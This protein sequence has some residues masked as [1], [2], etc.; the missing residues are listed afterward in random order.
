MSE[1]VR[2]LDYS[3]GRPSAAAVINNGYQFVM[4]YLSWE[5]NP[6]DLS[7]AE[8]ADMT[9]AGVGV[10][11]VFET[12]AERALSG[13]WGGKADAQA[14]VFLAGRRGLPDSHVHYFAVDFDALSHQFESVRNYFIGVASVIP[15]SR[16]GVYGSHAVCGMLLDVELV[17]Y[18]WQTEAWSAGLWDDRFHMIQRAGYVYVDGIQCDVN[19]LNMAHDE[20]GIHGMGDDVGQLTGRQGEMLE[21]LYD[22]FAKPFVQNGVDVGDVLARLGRLFPDLDPVVM[23]EYGTLNPGTLTNAIVSHYSDYFRWLRQRVEAQGQVLM[24]LAERLDISDDEMQA[25]LEEA[26]RNAMSAHVEGRV[27]VTLNPRESASQPA[28]T[29]ALPTDGQLAAQ[30]AADGD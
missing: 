3:V 9:G 7:A 17:T 20:W 8:L 21:Q 28:L 5:D 24:A 1:Q 13:Y 15:L 6:K 19:E 16:I 23:D 22:A 2:G 25:M 11:T 18:C 10:G 4:R 30:T 29:G 14:A 27:V 26:V 12:V